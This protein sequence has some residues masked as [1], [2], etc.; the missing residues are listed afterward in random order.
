MKF[1]H[2]AGDEAFAARAREL[3]KDIDDEAMEDVR[4]EIAKVM[5]D[6]ISLFES[7]VEKLTSIYVRE[8][9]EKLCMGEDYDIESIFTAADASE[10]QIKTMAAALPEY[11]DMI[12]AAYDD[13]GEKNQRLVM[14]FTVHL[15]HAAGFGSWSE[16]MGGKRSYLTY[17]VEMAVPFIVTGYGAN[18]FSV[19]DGWSEDELNE[20][21]AY[22]EA[23]TEDRQL[24]MGCI[25]Y[26]IEHE[27]V[28]WERYGVTI[29]RRKKRADE[30]EADSEKIRRLLTRVGYEPY[31]RNSYEIIKRDIMA[32]VEDNPSPLLISRLLSAFYTW[33]GAYGEQR[34]A[35]KY[36]ERIRKLILEMREKEPQCY[37]YMIPK[38]AIEIIESQGHY[39]E[40]MINTE[41]MPDSFWNWFLI[42][43]KR[44]RRNDKKL[45]SYI[46]IYEANKIKLGR[47]E[48]KSALRKEFK[49]DEK[50]N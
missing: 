39:H 7:E 12:C 18:T 21:V 38:L 37:N 31:Q 30:T 15:K 24:S 27:E 36:A 45:L 11:M 33:Q 32:D 29:T 20:L 47:L 2:S 44:S 6:N 50:G 26:I 10:P 42:G 8:C 16:M 13:M 5:Y 3:F 4:F 41:T 35:K 34:E 22:V 48:I 1:K 17:L 28:D 43:A 46:R 25:K 19:P 14:N 23:S 40:L 49:D 9:I